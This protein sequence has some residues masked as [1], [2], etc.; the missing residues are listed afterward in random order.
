M[1]DCHLTTHAIS[2]FRE[3]VRPA[4]TWE[5]AERELGAVL[6]L[7]EETPH[8]PAWLAERQRHHADLYR[9]LGDLVMPLTASTVTP[10]RWLVTTC[11]TRGGISDLAREARN[12]RRQRRHPPSGQKHDRTPR[13]A[14]LE[15]QLALRDTHALNASWRSAH[16]R[17][18]SH[19]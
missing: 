12:S 7:A 18:K 11:L 4:L 6:A 9:V 5:H 1:L 17:H 3:R 14:R 19:A 16:N 2:R 13:H 15:C 10:G 8:A